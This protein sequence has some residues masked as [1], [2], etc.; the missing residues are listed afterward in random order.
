MKN[1][2]RKTLI[3]GLVVVL[4]VSLLFLFLRWL[5]NLV[6]DLI[7]PF[8]VRLLQ[9]SAVPE[10]AADILVFA[11][12]LAVCF[13]IG[14]IVSTEFGLLLHRLADK[15]LA[16]I[17]PGYNFIREVVL[18]VFGDKENSP[19]AN[20]EVVRAQVFGADIPTTVTGIITSRHPDGNV[21]IFVPTGP[22][23]TS[24]QIFHLPESLVV[25]L[26]VKVDEMMRT[27]IGCGA[28]SGKLFTQKVGIQNHQTTKI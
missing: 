7:Q 21:T 15:Y 12:I 25:I 11:I 19:F 3:G 14:L 16:K 27:V 2:L 20:G 28:G 10:F 17:A 24:G 6:T 18:Q 9:H 5:Y 26:P 8:S 22:N 23:P 1:F 13:V 4:P